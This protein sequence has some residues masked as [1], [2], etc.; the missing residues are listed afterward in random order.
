MILLL[1]AAPLIAFALPVS[2]LAPNRRGL[3]MC[4]A[5]FFAALWFWHM[6]IP[7][8]ST[9]RSTLAYWSMHLSLFGSA[10]LLWRELMHHRTEDTFKALMAGLLTSMHM[11]M[12]G[13]VLALASHPLFSAHLLTAPPWGLNALQ[14]QQ[15]GGS[16]MWIPGIALFLWT[17]LRSF[18]RMWVALDGAKTA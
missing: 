13:A 1:A 10:I 3:W 6:P 2:T 7:Y 5:L 9:F 11:G 12:L 8:D 16:I 18:R 15:L 17:A 4:A 14:D